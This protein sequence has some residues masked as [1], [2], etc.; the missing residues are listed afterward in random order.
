MLVILIIGLGLFTIVFSLLHRRYHRRRE[1][2][3]SQATV[4]NP[5]INTWGPGQS[6]HDFGAY[7]AGIKRSLSRN[8][9][10]NRN[11][12]GGGDGPKGKETE[13]RGMTE[14]VPPVPALTG[15]KAARYG[16][17]G[18]GSR[19]PSRGNTMHGNHEGGM[20]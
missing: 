1:L 14:V 11:K 5:D 18:G 12:D 7:A 15:E 16:H 20:F 6:V 2:Q 3:W 13:G 17:G 19:T 8:K 4:S 10:K 9:N